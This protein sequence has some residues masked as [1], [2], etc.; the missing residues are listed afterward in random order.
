MRILPSFTLACC[1]LLA[2]CGQSDSEQSHAKSE[3]LYRSTGSWDGTPYTRYPDGP[4]VLSV[5]KTTVPPYTTLDWHCHQAL[6][7]GHLLEGTLEV[8][9]RDGKRVKLEAGD[10]LAELVNTVHRGHTQEQAATVLVFHASNEQLAFST[11]EDQCQPSVAP[12]DG[13]M[14]TL[15]DQLEKRLETAKDVALHKWDNA[16]P[17]RAAERE[18]ALLASVRHQAWRHKLAE[19]RAVSVFTDQIEAH[20][21]IQYNLLSRWQ[22]KGGAPDTPRRDLA[23][24]LRPELDA[25]QSELLQSLAN[26]DNSYRP[27]CAQRLAVAI[28]SRALDPSLRHAMVRATAQL[29]NKI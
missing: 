3:V 4:P 5:V 13:P 8:E 2:G 7:L 15:L 20:K 21:L 9:S 24:A 23:G 19:E 28:D 6:N 12:D 14:N 10:S 16:Q 27:D 26:F 22:V 29:C 1:A 11:P 25:Q 18:R 17:V